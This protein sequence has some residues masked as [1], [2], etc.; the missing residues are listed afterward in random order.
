MKAKDYLRQLDRIHKLIK[1][2]EEKIRELR[3]RAVYRPNRISYEGRG[4]SPGDRVSE[5]VASICSVE[6]LLVLDKLR[7]SKMEKLT[8][9]K[10]RALADEGDRQLLELRYVNRKHWDE[11]ADIMGY[12]SIHV[13]G[14]LHNRALRAFEK[15]AEATV[16]IWPLTLA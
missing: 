9:D 10:L 6:D 11:I 15:A 2:K 13:R 7:L 1:A 5:M 16:E 4:N 12:S 3:A 8:L 14:S